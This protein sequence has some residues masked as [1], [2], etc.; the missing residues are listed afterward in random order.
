VLVIRKFGKSGATIEKSG[1][2]PH[3]NELYRIKTK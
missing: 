1:G 2:G 3:P